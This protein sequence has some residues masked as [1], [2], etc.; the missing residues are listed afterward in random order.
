[1]NAQRIKNIRDR[2]TAALEPIE[3]KITD[4]SHKHVGHEGA[5]SGRGHFHVHIA[6]N[7]FLNLSQVHRHR[8]I[9]AAIGD[10]MDTDIHA[11]SINAVAPTET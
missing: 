3:L 10:L 6:S 7:Q 2:L 9:Y 4:E 1:M 5:K 8:L 11:L